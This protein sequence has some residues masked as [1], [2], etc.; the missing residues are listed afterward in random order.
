[1]LNRIDRAN[2]ADEDG[3]RLITINAIGFPHVIKFERHFTRTGKK[4]AN[5]MR[6]LTFMHGGAFIGS[7]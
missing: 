4:F 5:L 2:A 1:M 3:N 6:E 7:Q